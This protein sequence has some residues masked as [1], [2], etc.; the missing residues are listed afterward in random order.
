[1]EAEKRGPFRSLFLCAG[2]RELSS[3]VVHILRGR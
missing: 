3:K 1:M 2:C